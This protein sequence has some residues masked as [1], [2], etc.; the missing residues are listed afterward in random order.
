MASWRLMTFPEH[1]LRSSREGSLR[2]CVAYAVAV[3][4]G[5]QLLP[6]AVVAHFF[7]VFAA[8]RQ[9]EGGTGIRGRGQSPKAGT[10][11]CEAPE[12][13]QRSIR[14][15]PFAPSFLRVAYAVGF[16]APCVAWKA[17]AVVHEG[18]QGHEEKPRPRGGAKARSVDRCSPVNH[19]AG[20]GDN[21]R[22]P[23]CA[24]APT[25]WSVPWPG[26]GQATQRPWRSWR[27][28]VGRLSLN[29]NCVRAGKA[30]CALAPPR[31]L[32]S[33]SAS[34]ATAF[35]IGCR[36]ALL[37]CFRG[38]QAVRGRNGISRT[39]TVPKS[40]DSPLARSRLIRLRRRR[41]RRRRRAG[42]VACSR[43]WSPRAPGRC[44]RGLLRPRR[45]PAHRACCPRDA[46]CPCGA[47]PRA[48]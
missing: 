44:R 6:L 41:G 25:L 20:A 40:G 48:R 8:H 30:L 15:R 36:R 14:A 37:L 10:V 32:C 33:G 31:G 13:K 29:T 17:T 19:P 12:Q 28:G 46:R 16:P 4:R 3:L 35:A 7:C 2:L 45:P 1:E 9:F 38:P 23:G 26:V 47:A 42:P 21:A 39:G 34:W 24:T 18:H 22:A 5:Q 27:P 43:G 11:P